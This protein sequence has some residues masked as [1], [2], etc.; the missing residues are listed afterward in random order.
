[1]Y[2]YDA[3]R[4]RLR[5]GLVD[6]PIDQYY[7]EKSQFCYYQGIMDEDDEQYA[8]LLE[9]HYRNYH[10][11]E[12]TGYGLQERV[13]T[14]EIERDKNDEALMLEAIEIANKYYETLTLNHI[15]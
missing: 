14:F 8:A 1:M 11:N 2:L 10:F 12:E 13:K 4:A 9:Q 5:Y 3:D 6:C 15:S 7:F